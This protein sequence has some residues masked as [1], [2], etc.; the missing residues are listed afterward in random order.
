MNKNVN[1]YK[2][3]EAEMISKL[4]TLERLNGKEVRTIS[5]NLVG[6]P[7]ITQQILVLISQLYQIAQK[8]ADF[9]PLF[10]IFQTNFPTNPDSVDV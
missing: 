2:T 6:L 3:I 10:L 4:L 1:L 7:K 9:K 8:V 5:H